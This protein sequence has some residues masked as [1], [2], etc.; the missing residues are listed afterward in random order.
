MA[1]E[2]GLLD[3]RK[4]SEYDAEHVMGSSNFPLDFINQNMAEIKKD[5]KYYLYCATGYRSLIAASIL[6]ARGF[7]NVVN[8]TGGW[9]EIIETPMERTEYVE[10]ITEL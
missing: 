6:K 5:L 2:S 4:K 7:K 8:V 10:Q 9:K 1:L 3:T